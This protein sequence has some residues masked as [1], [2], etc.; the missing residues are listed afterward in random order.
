VYVY[1]YVYAYAYA[2]AYVY[3]YVYVYVIMYV[4]VYVYVYVYIC[5]C[6]WIWIHSHTHRHYHM[7]RVACIPVYTFIF[8]LNCSSLVLVSSQGIGQLFAALVVG[9]ARNPS[10]KEDLFTCPSGSA[11]CNCYFDNL[12]I[13]STYLPSTQSGIS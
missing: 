6:L 11:L 1:V 7:Y 2:Y 9:M 13:S 4:Y 5:L 10:M 3:A 12:W 8:L